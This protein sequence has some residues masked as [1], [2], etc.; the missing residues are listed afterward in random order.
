MK[1]KRTKHKDLN[2]KKIAEVL[3]T[4]FDLLIS[5]KATFS[6]TVIDYYQI[7]LESF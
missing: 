3:K 7:T 1:K 4:R 6:L 2:G 5:E